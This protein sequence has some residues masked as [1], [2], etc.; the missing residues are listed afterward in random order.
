M[1]KYPAVLAGQRITASLLASMLPDV[2][3]KTT[4][5]NLAS[6]TTL[7][8]DDELFS[9]VEA[10]ATYDVELWLLHSSD[11]GADG[12]IKVGWTGPSGA[13]MT[14][15]VQGSNEAATSST[16]ATSINLQTRTIGETANFGGGGSTGTSAYIRGRLTTAGTAGTLRLQ[17]AQRSSSATAT[18]VR[19][20][21][22]LRLRRTA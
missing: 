8:N 14:W 21:S 5:E 1:S 2:V 15:G 20:G 4:T 18:Q 19:A 7:Q 6:S 16:A 3:A 12:D 22:I 13:S 10:N 9:S 17:W 11:S